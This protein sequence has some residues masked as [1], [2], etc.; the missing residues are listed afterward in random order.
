MTAREL[1]EA[2][3]EITRYFGRCYL[4]AANTT[5]GKELYKKYMEA[6]AL[7]RYK[8]EKKKPRTRELARA[9]RLMGEWYD[10]GVRNSAVRKPLAWALFQTWKQIE[11]ETEEGEG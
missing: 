4:N 10:R 8:V 9:E 7:A 11:Q 5:K 1:T 2:L 3:E 6:T